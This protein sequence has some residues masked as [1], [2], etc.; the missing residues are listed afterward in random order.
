MIDSSGASRL[1]NLPVV[2][3]LFDHKLAQSFKPAASRQLFMRADEQTIISLSHGHV[4][5][6]APSVLSVRAL[7]KERLLIFILLG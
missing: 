6:N 4:E 2:H 3:E 7:K 1:V 5:L